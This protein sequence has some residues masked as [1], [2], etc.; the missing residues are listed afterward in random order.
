MSRPGVTRMLYVTVCAST[1]RSTS[2]AVPG[3]LLLGPYSVVPSGL[4]LEDAPPLVAPDERAKF[5]AID[6]RWPELR[7]NEYTTFWPRTVLASDTGSPPSVS[8]PVASAGT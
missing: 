4:S 6:R 8:V 7:E 3:L 5:S 1:T 2:Q